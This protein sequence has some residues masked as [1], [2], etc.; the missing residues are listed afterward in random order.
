MESNRFKVIKMVLATILFFASE[1]LACPEVTGITFSPSSP[2]PIGESV[3]ATMVIGGDT[4]G[5]YTLTYKWEEDFSGVGESSDAVVLNDPIIYDA[6]ATLKWTKDGKSGENPVYDFIVAFAV[7]SVTVDKT[8]IAKGST[9]KI[10]ATANL[11]P[12][13][14]AIGDVSKFMQWEIYRNGMSIKN[15]S[16]STTYDLGADNDAGKKVSEQ[17]LIFGVRINSADVTQNKIGFDLLPI[18]GDSTISGSCKVMLSSPS[19]DYTITE[20]NMDASESLTSDFGLD[21]IPERYYNKITI[22]WNVNGVEAKNTF[23]YMIKN[24]GVCINTVYFTLQEK[25]CG[26][27]KKKALVIDINNCQMQVIDVMSDFASKI[28]TEGSGDT[29]ASVCVGYLEDRTIEPC[30]K[31]LSLT[32]KLYYN[33]YC[34]YFF[35]KYTKPTGS[36]GSY[37]QPNSSIAEWSGNTIVGCTDKIWF[38]SLSVIKTIQD[39]G[40]FGKDASDDARRHHF[41]HYISYDKCDQGS[42]LANSLAIK[43]F[44]Q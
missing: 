1:I 34:S 27:L 9:D 28:E 4:E 38:R 43:I 22:A 39:T 21:S 8:I 42:S 10:T 35:K 41:D 16:G 11:L 40:S 23:E 26:G 14:T 32:D 18:G 29:N 30:W 6:K 5:G 19:G 12:V 33:L 2:Q 7:D 44:N 25:N 36:C 37:V 3:T 24:L 17:L 31:N 13:N 20:K 15:A